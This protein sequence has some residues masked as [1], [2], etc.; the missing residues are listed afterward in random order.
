MGFLDS[1]HRVRTSFTLGVALLLGTLL[2]PVSSRAQLYS[3]SVTG[4]V[5]DPSGAT[6][7][8][9]KV[10]LVDQNKGYPFPATT[11][12][13]GRYLIRSVPPGTYK[14][15]VEAKGFQTE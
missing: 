13:A 4:V 14:I 2:L 6:V 8:G 5:T 15:R 12:S 10:T 9:A 3:G 1:I 11:D 7:P